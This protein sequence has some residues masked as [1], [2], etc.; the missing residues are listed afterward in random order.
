MTI[1]IENVI[2]LI[3][4]LNDPKLNKHYENKLEEITNE[5]GFGV[6]L[7]KLAS[8]QQFDMVHRQF[9]GILLKKYISKHWNDFNDNQ[10]DDEEIDDNLDEH[11][12]IQLKQMK[13]QQQ[14]QTKKEYRVLLKEEKIEIKKLLSPCLSDPSSKIRTAIAMCIAKI[15]A[16]EWP[17]EWPELVDELIGCLNRANAGN[18]NGVGKNNDLLHGVIRCLELL[19]DPHD[20]NISDEQI[21]KL[22]KQVYPVF[23][24]LLGRDIDP[25]IHIRIINVFRSTVTHLTYMKGITKGLSKALFPFIPTWVPIFIGHLSRVL[26]LSSPHI[27]HYFTVMSAIIEIFTMLIQDF[28]KKTSKYIQEILSPIWTLFNN[29]FPIYEKVEINPV[30]GIVSNFVEEGITKIDR[31]VS[32]IFDFMQQIVENQSLAPL[33]KPFLKPIFANSIQYMQMNYELV[34]LWDSDPNLFLENEDD[35][36]YTP[37]VVSTTL[38]QSMCDIYKSDGT[39]YLFEV[40]SETLIKAQEEK[41]KSNKNWWKIRE[42]ALVALCDSSQSLSK[43][44]QFDV[45]SFL[46]TNLIQ[47][48]QDTINENDEDQGS[49]ILRG[50]S[51]ICASKF[52][53]LVDPSISLPFFNQA[54][55]LITQNVPI[56]L[57]LTAVMAIGSFAPKI[58]PQSIV[59]YIPSTVQAL[60]AMINQLSEDSLLLVLDCIKMLI[61]IDK[62]ITGQLEPLLIPHLSQTWINYANDPSFADALKEIFQIICACP[63]SYPGIL[64][65]M[66]PTLNIILSD[67]SNT[68]YNIIADSAADVLSLLM[69][70]VDQQIDTFLLDQLF[71]PILNILLTCDCQANRGILKASLCALLPFVYK[72]SSDLL[73]KWTFTPITQPTSPI[74]GLHALFLVL[75]RILFET[76][77]LVRVEVPSIISALLIRHSEII[78]PQ[79]LPLFETTLQAFYNCKLPSTKRAFSSVFARLII[80]HKTTI[81]DYL[82]GIPGPNGKGNALV[83]VLNEWQKYHL[84]MTSKLE[85]NVSVVAMCTLVSLNDPRLESITVDGSQIIPDRSTRDIRRKKSQYNGGLTEEWTKVNLFIKLMENLLETIKLEKE[86]L[87]KNSNGTAN[88][89]PQDHHDSDEDYEEDDEDDEDDEETTSKRYP[90]IDENG[91]APAEDYAHM[92]DGGDD[93]DLAEYLQDEFTEDTFEIISKSDPLY[94][95]EII[96]YLSDFFTNLSKNSPSV[97]TIV[98]PLLN[99]FKV[100][101]FGK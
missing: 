22:V 55:I 90:N 7:A 30:H 74:N 35:T 76:D 47:D 50:R 86:E 58:S 13:L 19:C 66:I 80:Q 87:A 60:I 57:K 12:K 45:V 21:E 61:R 78:G 25:M 72:T 2:E 9:S 59:D 16:Y 4:G 89:S 100:Q 18:D 51:L 64:Q 10:S 49:L 20:G 63:K 6:V 31:L 1:T 5:I 82:A 73:L 70:R 43:I 32:S 65:R 56:T 81:I 88:P 75:R 97:F 37:R 29:C 39:K 28:P 54:V 93:D 53:K 38:V 71:A 34:D 3:N 69:A 48:F 83:F 8:G 27:N 98:A 99:D 67:Y 77:E 15:G 94:H 40:I 91:F 14:Q 96:K 44:K 42:A 62:D 95:V 85:N 92:I 24:E 36:T 79:T 17:H 52:A 101:S 26:D 68:M 11:E 23:S 46:S 41:T 33:F 84:E